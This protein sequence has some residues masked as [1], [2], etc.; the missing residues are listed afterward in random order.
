MSKRGINLYIT[1]IKNA[2]EKIEEYTKDLDFN[3]FA[4]DKK[5]IDMENNKRRFT[6]F[7]KANF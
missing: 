7:Q 2:I 3:D 5:T 1:D 4:R 6:A